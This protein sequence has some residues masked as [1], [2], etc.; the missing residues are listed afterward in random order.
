MSGERC[1]SLPTFQAMRKV[2]F[3]EDGFLL[4]LFAT[5]VLFFSLIFFTIKS[6]RAKLNSLQSFLDFYFIFLFKSFII[7][8][9]ISTSVFSCPAMPT[10]QKISNLKVSSAS[11]DW[12][13]FS[14]VKKTPLAIKTEV[15]TSSLLMTTMK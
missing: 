15:I 2:D 11:K 12:E 5:G 14:A 10:K 4:N 7:Y 13:S 1:R 9:I 6:L 3:C 8:F